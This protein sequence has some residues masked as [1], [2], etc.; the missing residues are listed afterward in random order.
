[1]SRWTIIYKDGEAVTVAG[2]NIEDALDSPHVYE[3]K[4][5]IIAVMQI[6]ENDDNPF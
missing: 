3:Y 6:G 4:D 5:Q 1:M 2:G